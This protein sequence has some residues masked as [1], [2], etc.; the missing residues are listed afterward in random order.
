MED[1]AGKICPY[2]RTMIHQGEAVVVC[3]ECGIPHHESC[4]NDNKGCTTFGCGQHDAVLK[5]PPGAVCK[6][7]G[8][9]MLPD[10][11]FC[12]KCGT[13]K[14]AQPSQNACQSCGAP[15]LPDQ[16]FCPKCGTRKSAP[17]M[18]AVTSPGSV[19]PSVGQNTSPYYANTAAIS[20]APAQTYA[21][22]QASTICQ[23]CG[24]VLAPNEEYC[25]KCGTIRSAQAPAV[26]QKCGASML[27]GQEFCPRCGNKVGL[28][29]DA[30][31]SS[32]IQQF[33]AGITA[34]NKKSKKK[35]VMIASISAAVVLLVVLAV[36]ILPKIFRST[37][38]YLTEG[39]YVKAYSTASTVSEKQDVVAENTIANCSGKAM[40]SMKDSK[41]FDLRKAW[42]NSSN[43]TCVVLQVAGNN[44]YGNTVL[45]Y[46]V[47]Y[48]SFDDAQW[49]LWDSYYDLDRKEYSIYDTSS[50][51]ADK[52]IYNSGI[53][54]I[55]EN[56]VT[57]YQLDQDAV[58]RINGLFKSGDLDNVMLIPQ[59]VPVDTS[60]D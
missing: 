37:E 40:L 16:E 52:I 19:M 32:A 43:G 41:S 14:A 24:A 33:N 34:A 22:V 9:P 30:G 38:D 57:R 10:Q 15:M 59:A 21:P 8:A 42:Y 20:T 28:S 58:D 26:C 47:F 39:N 29:M 54:I 5:Q 12:P 7:C 31:V 44:S 25:R 1:H 18:A 17:A 60:S 11:D 2:C 49:K 3:P 56:A 55:E 48:Y 23:G 45:N 13:R 51:S 35:P 6:A 50:E 53:T 46:W 36:I 4:W 27:P